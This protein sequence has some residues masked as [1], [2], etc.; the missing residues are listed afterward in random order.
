MDYVWYWIVEPRGELTLGP[1]SCFSV[2][3]GLTSMNECP[4]I[5][6]ATEIQFLIC[7][8]RKLEDGVNHVTGIA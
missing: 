7:A 3:C 5:L 2:V 4:V 6:L 1:P 8:K